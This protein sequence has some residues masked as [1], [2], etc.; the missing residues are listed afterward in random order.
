MDSLVVDACGMKTDSQFVN[1]FEDQ[2]PSR[3]AMKR[4]LSDSAWAETMGR[5]KDLMRAC[6]IGNWQS[7]PHQQQQNPAERRWQTIK[8][9]TNN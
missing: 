2:M 4:L 6:V 9:R 8:R 3:G 1:A 7:E 5:A